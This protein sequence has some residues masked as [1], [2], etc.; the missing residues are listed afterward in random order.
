MCGLTVGFLTQ[1]FTR[2][3]RRFTDC[4]TFIRRFESGRRLFS[5]PR[6]YSS[7]LTL[8]D[9][10]GLVLIPPVVSLVKPDPSVFAI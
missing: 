2:L 7:H 1:R 9:H 8:G 6:A 5:C 10:R 4:K 3:S